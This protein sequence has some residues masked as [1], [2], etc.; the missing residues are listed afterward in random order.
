MSSK[1]L[2]K[3]WKA[4]SNYKKKSILKKS[5][6]EENGFNY[7]LISGQ[8]VRISFQKHLFQ[9]KNIYCAV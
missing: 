6:K 4:T 2:C 1:H 3:P 5:R 7:E 9:Q 8:R